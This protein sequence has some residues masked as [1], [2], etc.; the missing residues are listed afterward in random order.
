MQSVYNDNLSRCIA[1][2]SFCCYTEVDHPIVAK[3]AVITENSRVNFSIYSFYLHGD[4]ISGDR[5]FPDWKSAILLNPSPKRSQYDYV[6]ELLP[7]FSV[8]PINKASNAHI[9]LDKRTTTHSNFQKPILVKLEKEVY[10]H[11]REYTLLPQLLETTF[12]RKSR[13]PACRYIKGS[14]CRLP[15]PLRSSAARIL[16]VD[17][18]PESLLS[19]S[20]SS[21]P[22]RRGK[23][24]V[25][26]QRASERVGSM[27]VYILIYT[28]TQQR[29]RAMQARSFLNLSLDRSPVSFRPRG[30]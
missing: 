16:A 8:S 5:Q 12:A 18:I 4:I 26:A 13:A 27:R 1:K 3:N 6:L 19:L 2:L 10:L 28:N 30:A 29:V 7:E 17:R 14:R 25:R 24:C 22:M 21:L 11:P 23:K 9:T 20:L 15:P